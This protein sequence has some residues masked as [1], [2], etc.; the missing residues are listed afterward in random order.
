MR[1]IGQIEK[2]KT[3]LLCEPGDHSFLLS[4]SNLPS[5]ILKSK[6]KTSLISDY[7]IRGQPFVL[8]DGKTFINNNEALEWATVF[9]FSPLMNGNILNPY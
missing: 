7:Y 6:K 1:A 3:K 8:E 9:G 5:K 2:S 4:G